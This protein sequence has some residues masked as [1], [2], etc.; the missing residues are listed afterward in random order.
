MARATL[1]ITVPEHVWVGRVSRAYPDARLRILAALPKGDHGVALAEVTSS[2]LPDLVGDIRTADMVIDLDLLQHHGETA[3]IQ[4]ETTTPL[5]LQPIKSSGIPLEMPFDIQD[6]QA[7]WEIN[8]PQSHLSELADKL[9]EFGIPYEV[10]ELR[11]EVEPD[12]ALTPRQR[13]LIVE[14]V[15]RGYYDTPRECTLTD[16][17]EAMDLAKSTCSETLHRAEETII[18]EFVEELP[19]SQRTSGD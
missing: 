18:K 13:T 10:E 17:A 6:G 11:Q 15:E 2:Q 3:V 7:K 14:A 9:E 1:T 4:F 19:E 16:L 12:P 5:L 8:A